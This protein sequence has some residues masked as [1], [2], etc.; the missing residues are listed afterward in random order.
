MINKKILIM[1]SIEKTSL[2][3]FSHDNIYTNI[4]RSECV[5]IDIIDFLGLSKYY[6]Y[7]YKNKNK[8][9]CLV[10]IYY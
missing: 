1:T 3:S 8:N 9:I 2:F 10:L 4:V 6:L 7:Q 5:N